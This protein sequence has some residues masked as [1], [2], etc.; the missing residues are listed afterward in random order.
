M[1]RIT[2]QVILPISYSLSVFLDRVCIKCFNYESLHQNVTLGRGGESG[3]IARVGIAIFGGDISVSLPIHKS[4]L[5]IVGNGADAG[6][7]G[8]YLCGGAT[9]ILIPNE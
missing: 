3:F 4:E 6:V 5:K 9:R 8:V 1:G 2:E 7:E